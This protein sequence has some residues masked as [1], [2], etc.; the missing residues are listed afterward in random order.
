MRV[1]RLRARLG[2]VPIAIVMGNRGQWLLGQPFS[3]KV[4]EVFGVLFIAGSVGLAGLW[5]NTCRWQP[6][7]T[8]FGALCT[9]VPYIAFVAWVLST[10]PFQQ[11]RGTVADL[12]LIPYLIAFSWGRIIPRHLSEPD[13]EPPSD[14]AT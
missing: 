10:F 7:M 1:A 14:S 3:T 8:V 5:I 2:L 9:G 12:A 4:P 13:H 11:I 6:R